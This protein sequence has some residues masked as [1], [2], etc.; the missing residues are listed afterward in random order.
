MIDHSWHILGRAVCSFY[1]QDAGQND[2]RCAA[3]EFSKHDE[4][5]SILVLSICASARSR[6]GICLGRHTVRN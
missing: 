3:S 2:C 4:Q 6:V 5:L 1:E